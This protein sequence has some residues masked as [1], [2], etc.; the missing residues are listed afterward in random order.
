MKISKRSK[1]LETAE[2]EI[3][4]DLTV[5]V[6]TI[7]EIIIEI[8]TGMV[9][10]ITTTGIE[11]KIVETTVKIGIEA[12]EEIDLIPE[13]EE[14]LNLDLDQVK[15][16]LTETPSAVSAIDLVIQHITAFDW[17]TI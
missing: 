4:I 14:E 2:A 16:T 17:R 9:V 10:E 12:E 15:D 8:T 3:E 6:D 1:I 7:Q 11:V 5:E 13:K